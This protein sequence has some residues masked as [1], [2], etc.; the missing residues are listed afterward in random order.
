[1]D[2]PTLRTR[3]TYDAAAAQFLEN[4]RDRTA[5]VPW[6]DRLAADLPRG[7]RVLD[8]GAGPGID[9][10]ELR[11][12]G[13]HAVSLDFSRGMLLA[14]VREF[15]G[16]RVQG[17]ARRLPVASSSMKA[18]WANASLLHFP[19]DDFRVA[20]GEIARVLQASGVLY[21]TL[22]QGVGGE[23]ESSRYGEPRFFQYWTGPDLDA[24]LEAS[25]FRIIAAQ[26]EDGPRNVWLGR[27]ATLSDR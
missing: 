12:R 8:V 13:L 26:V 1:V 14:G 9:S 17:D 20:L 22:K 25:G 4:T 16:P 5:L 3:E 15:P 23:W 18:V 24:A 27:L 11:R 10:A 2:D 19:P 21:M 6:L 7:A